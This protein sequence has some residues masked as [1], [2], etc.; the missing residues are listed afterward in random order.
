MSQRDYVGTTKRSF[1]QAIVHL[2]ET[3]YGV[4]GSGR[5]VALLA[6]DIKA[7]ATQFYPEATHLS[8]GW[9]LFTGTKAIGGKAYPGQP[10]SDHELVT[11]PWPVCLP[12]DVHALATMPSGQAGKEGRQ[13]LLQ[14]R[15]V[16]LVEHGWQHP[17]GPVLLTLADLSCFLGIGTPQVSRLLQQA[18]QETGK[19]L[20][21]MGY[22]FDQGMKPT[23][24]GEV[25]TLYEAGLDEVEIAQRTHHA[26]SSVG[27]YLRDYERVKLSL[28]RQVAAA[29]I[30]QL[31]GLQPS[32]VK[33]YVELVQAHHPSLLAIASNC[34]FGA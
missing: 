4:L 18:R 33:A 14:Q 24:K 8:S 34:D 31:T 9:M 3:G 17:D 30:P 32:V 27:R 13:R 19:P 16:R 20:L 26:Q 6:A 11:I 22:Y 15:A 10:T 21:T 1:E 28:Q 29:E 2:L 23:H 5:I 7:L 12:S 25:I